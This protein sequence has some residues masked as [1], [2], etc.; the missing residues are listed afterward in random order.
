MLGPSINVLKQMLTHLLSEICLF[1]CLCSK[2]RK[3]QIIGPE[4][5]DEEYDGYAFNEVR[6]AFGVFPPDSN[7]STLM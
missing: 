6:R 4:E 3:A 5:E 1:L 2:G 7:R